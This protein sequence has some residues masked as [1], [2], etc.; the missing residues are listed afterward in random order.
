MKNEWM[1]MLPTLALVSACSDPS[2]T[3]DQVGVEVAF[4]TTADGAGAVADGQ[5]VIGG[6][7]GTLTI[8]DLRVIVDRFELRREDDDDCIEEDHSCERFSAPPLFIDVPLAGGSTVAVTQPVEPDTYR[9]L[10]FEI[11]DLDDDE[12]SPERAALIAQ[13]LADV[14]AEFPD[15]PREA[16][17]LVTGTFT[18]T[19]GDPQAYRVYFEAE[20]EVRMELD[21][22]AVVT[23]DG[24]GATFTV[25][26]DPALWFMRTDGTVR[27]LA[28]LD[29]DVTGDVEEFEI[30]IRDGFAEIEFDD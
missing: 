19:G 23:D 26:L 2:G 3:A 30:E 15:W 28:V 21:P 29:F 5:L 27:N 13:L 24:N 6:S 7:N 9:R 20:V 10:K 12:T 8:D 16:S 11:E 1:L 17:M 14:R 4:A 25:M 22:P 18:P